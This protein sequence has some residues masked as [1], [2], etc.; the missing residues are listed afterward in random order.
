MYKH[1]C[2]MALRIMMSLILKHV[3]SAALYVSLWTNWSHHLRAPG[4][5]GRWESAMVEMNCSGFSNA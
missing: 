4:G 1:I 2:R 5:L 3:P